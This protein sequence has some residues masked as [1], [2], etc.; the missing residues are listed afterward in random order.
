MVYNDCLGH[1]EVIDDLIKQ[2]SVM[3]SPLAWKVGKASTHF[4]K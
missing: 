2:E 4:V 1:T 3:V